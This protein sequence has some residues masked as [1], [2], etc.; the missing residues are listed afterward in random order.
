MVLGLQDDV[1]GR[2][3]QKRVWIEAIA[4]ARSLDFAQSLAIDILM[5]LVWASSCW[6]VEELKCVWNYVAVQHCKSTW[7]IHHQ[8]VLMNGGPLIGQQQRW[9]D[10][11]ND[12]LKVCHCV[13]CVC[14]EE[15]FI[16]QW[17]VLCGM[18]GYIETDREFGE[19]GQSDWGDWNPMCKHCHWWYDAVALLQT[20]QWG[21]A[22]VDG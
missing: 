3:T 6:A 19:I 9:A 5:G 13:G 2:Q 8:C 10:P 1:L 17:W 21:R 22:L 16:V 20:V 11:L 4:A 14:S 7:S 18:Q 15:N 12:G